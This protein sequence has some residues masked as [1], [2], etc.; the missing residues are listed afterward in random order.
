MS[1]P[2]H[3]VSHSGGRS[4]HISSVTPAFSTRVDLKDHPT[5][6]QK[7]MAGLSIVWWIAALAALFWWRKN[8]PGVLTD[9]NEN[10]AG[11]ASPGIT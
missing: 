5:A 4:I 10:D 11:S 7:I 6:E 9:S 1:A 8:A 2:P 3:P